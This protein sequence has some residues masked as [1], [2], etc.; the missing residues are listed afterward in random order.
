MCVFLYSLAKWSCSGLRCFL[1]NQKWRANARLLRLTMLHQVAATCRKRHSWMVTKSPVATF[2]APALLGIRRGWVVSFSCRDRVTRP[3]SSPSFIIG[4]CPAQRSVEAA[5]LFSRCRRMSPPL[6]Q[7]LAG[8]AKAKRQA[9][10]HT[11]VA[12]LQ[13]CNT[14]F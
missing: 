8:H 2:L 13:R 7:R 4:T 1:V 14:Y 6:S 10:E 9:Y 5:S 3:I 12:R 11:H